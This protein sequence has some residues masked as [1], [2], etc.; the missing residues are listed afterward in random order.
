MQNYFSLPPDHDRAAVLRL[1]VVNTAFD[2]HPDY[3]FEAAQYARER[4]AAANADVQR[5]TA[6]IFVPVW[7]DE[8]K[9]VRTRG[10]FGV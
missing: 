5:T 2:G 3:H 1:V 6:A 4:A 10:T 9:N 8:G 7:F